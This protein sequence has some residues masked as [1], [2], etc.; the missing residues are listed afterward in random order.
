MIDIGISKL[1]II[2]ATA[3]I[4]IGPERLPR[5]A[6]TAGT[7]YGRAQRYW[8]GVKSEVARQIESEELRGLH[9]LHEQVRDSARGIKVEVERI[10]DEVGTVVAEVKAA[11]FMHTGEAVS[12]LPP[13][14]APAPAAPDDDAGCKARVFRTKK[15][16][17]A[18]GIPSW[19]RKRHE[20]RRHAVSAAA[21]AR[22]FRPRRGA[23]L[24]MSFF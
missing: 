4:V 14:T 6:R 16:A 23:G 17:K 2:G 10:G 12:A 11:A 8:Q 18:P 9:D 15:L 19:Y 20:R 21:R 3:L 22:R 1:A 13:D 7:L 24:D 5:V